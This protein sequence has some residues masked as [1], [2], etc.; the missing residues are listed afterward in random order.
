MALHP[1]ERKRHFLDEA[2]VIWDPI[3]RVLEENE[4]WYRDL[5]E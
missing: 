4:D 2:T 1:G 5:V 3:R